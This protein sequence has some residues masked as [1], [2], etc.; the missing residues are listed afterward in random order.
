MTAVRQ[1][2]TVQPDGRLEIAVPDLPPGAVAEVIVLLT[3]AVKSPAEPTAADRLV[4]LHQLQRGLNLSAQD[5]ENWQRDVRSERQ[6]WS[7]PGDVRP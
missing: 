2:A 3:P 5:V 4:A 1:T 6:A 7:L